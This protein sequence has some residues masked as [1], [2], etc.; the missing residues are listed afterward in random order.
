[1]LINH[2]YF[3]ANRAARNSPQV[4]GCYPTPNPSTERWRI[5]ALVSYIMFVSCLSRY[6]RTAAGAALTGLATETDCGSN[7]R[8][9]RLPCTAECRPT[10]DQKEDRLETDGCNSSTVPETAGTIYLNVKLAWRWKIVSQKNK[11]KNSKLH[12]WEQEVPAFWFPE[13]NCRYCRGPLLTCMCFC[14]GVCMYCVHNIS[15]RQRNMRRQFDLGGIPDHSYCC[16]ECCVTKLMCSAALGL[17][18]SQELWLMD[19]SQKASAGQTCFSQS[20]GIEGKGT[21]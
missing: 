11:T 20:T 18:L 1:M 13:L 3:A 21:I 15:H 2:T 8:T 7:C 6:W 14:W 17:L 16:W 12:P 4:I 9:C 5:C 19:T 10:W